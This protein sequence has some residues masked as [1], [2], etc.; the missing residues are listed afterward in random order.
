MRGKE[1]KKSKGMSKVSQRAMNHRDIPGWMSEAAAAAVCSLINT[2]PQK[3]R[4]IP[5]L[6]RTPASSG[7]P[8]DS[9][10]RWGELLGDAFAKALPNIQQ[11]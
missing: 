11:D 10:G 2:G 7:P 5:T 3:Q 6:A 1:I 8:E 4:F 9:D